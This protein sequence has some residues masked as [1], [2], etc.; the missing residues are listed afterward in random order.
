VRTRVAAVIVLSSA[1]A[2]PQLAQAQQQ[3][4][5]REVPPPQGVAVA[6]AKGLVTPLE[7]QIV[8]SK[9]QGDKRISSIPYVLAV[10]A[11]SS[12]AQLTVGADVPVQSTTFIPATAA[13]GKPA[14]PLRS[15]NYRNVGTNIECSAVTAEDGRFE[16][17]VSVDE[18][19]L[20]TN[21]AADSKGQPAVE[22]PVF[23]S[24]KSRN[25]VLL[26]S[27]Q[28]RQYTAATDRVSGETV[29][30]EVTLTVVK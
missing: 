1:L 25:K 8:I 23:R 10:N 15:F 20:V 3:A 2:G 28:T 27:G 12:S 16:L 11:N 5:R 24:F 18:S 22:M 29:R 30:I 4:E 13:D 19:S 7:V 6:G 14:S 9:F 26:R 21:V 17:S